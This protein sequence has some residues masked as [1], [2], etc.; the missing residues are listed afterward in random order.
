MSKR[1]LVSLS[2]PF[3]L[4][5]L[6]ACVV[7]IGGGS[8]A[9]NTVYGSGVPATESRGVAEFTRVEVRGS[10][11]VVAQ[12]GGATSLSLVGDDNLLQYVT[13]EVEDGTLV[14]GMESGSYDFEVDL[15]VTLAT[16]RLESLAV[17]GSADCELSGFSG[18]ALELS[19][20][21]S[22]EVRATGRVDSLAVSIR[23]SGDMRLEDLEARSASVSIAGSGDVRLNARETLEV[24]IA[25][26]GDVRFRGDPQ[27]QQSI[28]GSGDVSRL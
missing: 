4:A 27:V 18:G 12:V 23:G 21:G 2:F 7:S 10:A 6:A 9:L 28:A 22:G 5:P 24:G 15:V 17:L 3:V 1:T 13:T 25:G 26:S 8:C 11:D 14:I 16:P 20:A 19:I